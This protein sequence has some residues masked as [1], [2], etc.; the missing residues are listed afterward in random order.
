MVC[1]A[2][3][4]PPAA[5]RASTVGP[6]TLLGPLLAGRA[7]VRDADRAGFE[8]SGLV[9]GRLPQHGANLAA[10]AFQLGPG[11]AAVPAAGYSLSEPPLA[12]F[13]ATLS[14]V[15]TNVTSPLDAS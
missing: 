6:A 14:P 12:V 8:K 13:S 10:R 9:R 3:R 2:R 11:P 7:P 4:R 1:V 15:I 5:S